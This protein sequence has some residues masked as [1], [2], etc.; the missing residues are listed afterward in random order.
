MNRRDYVETRSA[1]GVV[2]NARGEILV[3]NQEGTSW[4]LPKGHIKGS[5]SALSA[6]IREIKEETGIGE[7]RLIRELGSYTRP[8]ESPDPP[9]MKTI[10]MFLFATPQ[11]EL[12]P[13]DPANPRALWV[14]RVSVPRVLSNPVDKEFFSSVSNDLAS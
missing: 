3:V 8:A 12:N 14:R 4:S 1:G 13:L 10:T 5:E 6:A 7:L 9:E 2:V 11:L